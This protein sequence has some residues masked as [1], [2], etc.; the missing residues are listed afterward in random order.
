MKLRGKMNGDGDKEEARMQL[1]H[2]T[3]GKTVRQWNT[4]KKGNNEKGIKMATQNSFLSKDF[5]L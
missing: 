3:R 2:T 5:L 4:S 1:F